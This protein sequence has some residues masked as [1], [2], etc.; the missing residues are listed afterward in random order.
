[1]AISLPDETKRD[2]LSAIKQYFLEERD[3]EVGDLQASFLLDFVLKEIG[4]SIYNQAIKDAQ[5]R[6]SEAVSELDV[7][8]HEPETS[9]AARRSAARARGRG[10]GG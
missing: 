8:L 9:Y 6:L 10:A 2:I 1:M 5:A 4:P 7:S 3:E